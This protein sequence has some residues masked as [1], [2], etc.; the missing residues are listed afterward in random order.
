MLRNN[1]YKR[2]GTKKF[3]D[4]GT[5]TKTEETG[6]SIPTI[7]DIKKGFNINNPFVLD[8]YTTEEQPKGT[9]STTTNSFAPGT[10]SDLVK[11]PLFTTGF[12]P[13]NPYDIN[14][15]TPEPEQ[16][17][18]TKEQSDYF[19]LDQT[20]PETKTPETKEDNRPAM[21][22]LG[23]L[24]F[25][26]L[27]G[28]N[29]DLKNQQRFIESIQQR[30]SK[31]LYDYNY[32]Y[33]R[34]TSGGTEYQP[35]IK[36]EMG[37]KINKRYA[38]EG[39]ND[40]EIEGGEYIQLPNLETEMASG[41]SHSNGG[42]PTNLPDQTR[43]YSNNLKPEGSKKTFAQIAKN[44][45]TTSY[46][47]ILDNNFAKQVDKD[48]AQIMM[49][50]NQK[51]LDQLFADQQVMNGNSN[52]EVEAKNGA[53]INNPGFNSLPGYVQAK[54]IK[55]MANG[56]TDNPLDE[57]PRVQAIDPLN[58]AAMSTLNAI[59]PA[60]ESFMPT[61]MP[62]GQVPPAN[63]IDYFQRAY[64]DILSQRLKPRATMIDPSGDLP[65]VQAID[66]NNLEAMKTL[67]QLDSKYN[68]DQKGTL[69]TNSTSPAMTAA[70][71]TSNFAARSKNAMFDP[72]KPGMPAHTGPE[73]QFLTGIDP[74]IDPSLQTVPGVQPSLGTGVYGEASNIET[75]TK[76]YGWYLDDLKA[77]G[78]TFD[79]KREGDVRR[80][81]VA[82][83]EEAYNKFR[84]EGLSEQEA[85][86]KADEVGFTAV[87]GLQNSVDDMLGLYT[88]TR[89]LPESKKTPAPATGD[90]PF[91]D[92]LDEPKVTPST[93]AKG[94]VSTTQP[95]T[96]A[97][98]KGVTAQE[99]GK[100]IP[101]EFPLY[102]AI[103]EA[104]G[105][106]Q[107][108]Q[109][110]PYAIPEIDAA[111][112][113][114]QTLN[115]QSQLQDIDSMAT[116]TQR[117]GGDPLTTYIAGLDAKQRAF[118]AKQNYDAEGRS[119]ADMANA[120]NRMQADQ[121]NAQ[122]FDR[123]YNNLVGQARD[124]QSAEKQAAIASVTNKKAKFTQ[125]ETKKSAY[126]NALMENYD[127]DSK[128]NFTLKPGKNP[129]LNSNPGKTAKKGMYKK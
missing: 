47:K 26:A 58:L 112:V 40:V 44:Y 66:P 103:P 63:K 124:A 31:P 60:Q 28:K 61:A 54:I 111:Y 105:L 38:S 15:K 108:Q 74:S 119:R 122:Y 42:V 69:T 67:S 128:G 11:S 43:V 121:I 126:I 77:S 117:A 92:L 125:D 41:P 84:R 102:Q 114:P 45:D 22:S 37:A 115:I 51:I 30:N 89:V 78:E 107:S 35:T 14:P 2:F 80:A 113:R 64:S 83:T 123:V 39:M 62:G 32:M 91:M 73:K 118:Q 46:K 97:K 98:F 53:R 99:K 50:R 94:F 127:I 116:A 8:G 104:M 106:A 21:V 17:P 87:Q 33:G 56:G 57:L 90:K 19:V 13:L 95:V 49:Q 1:L 109:I 93:P 23:L 29:E 3:Q 82:F 20:M 25:D 7:E 68:V 88:A 120:Q 6:L 65:S 129:V 52:G 76:N 75:F 10:F 85:R 27:L 81:Q 96:G 110:Y 36:A 5:V 4:A 86:T 101:G 71:K 48:T 34:T 16:G 9:V 59:D 24:G 100:Y 72:T 70:A 12:S 79:P 55:N 18:M